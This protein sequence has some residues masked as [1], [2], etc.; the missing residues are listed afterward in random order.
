MKY[1][2]ALGFF[3]MASAGTCP[4]SGPNEALF[5]GDGGFLREYDTDTESF[6]ACKSSTTYGGIWRPCPTGWVP[7]DGLGAPVWHNSNICRLDKADLGDLTD[8]ICARDNGNFCPTSHVPVNGVCVETY[9][10]SYSNVTSVCPI[11]DDG[12]EISDGSDSGNYFCHNLHN[13]A[14]CPPGWALASWGS[15]CYLKKAANPED[16]ANPSGDFCPVG[17]SPVNGECV[18]DTTDPCAVDTYDKTACCLTKTASEYID[19]QCCE[20]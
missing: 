1:L 10:E 19:A 8:A 18:A 20:C 17:Q 4:S 2:L 14:D 15:A 3:G 7:A 13:L 9:C 5:C 12:V 11:F 16:C 6:Y